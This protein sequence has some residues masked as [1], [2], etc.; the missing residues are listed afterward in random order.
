MPAKENSD[1]F[2]KMRAQSNTYGKHQYY[3]CRAHDFGRECSQG[4]VRADIIDAQVISILKTLK[5]PADWHKKMI[6]A[7]GQLLG[8]RKLDERVGE[9]KEIIQRMDFR[10]DN[11]FI[12][13]R[14]EYIE[15]RLKLQ[16]QLEQLIPVPDDDLEHAADL[17]VN[18]TKH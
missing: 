17:L 14:D 9:I 4:S 7:M 12:T 1:S 3:R 10:W 6:S 16:Q 18:F 15:Q 11:G 8:D 13:N 5:P 2:G